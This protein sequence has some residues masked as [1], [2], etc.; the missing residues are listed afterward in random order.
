MRYAEKNAK[1]LE[2]ATKVYN[3]NLATCHPRLASSSI[4]SLIT[5]EALGV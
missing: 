4:P 1:K 3:S 2:A 5:L